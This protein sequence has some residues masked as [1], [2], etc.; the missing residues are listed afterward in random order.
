[1]LS[2]HVP[3][4][5]DRSSQFNEANNEAIR[6]FSNHQDTL[7]LAAQSE[8]YGLSSC[9]PVLKVPLYKK[10]NFTGD[11]NTYSEGYYSL[12]S[13]YGIKDP[14]HLAKEAIDNERIRFL[15]QTDKGIPSYVMNFLEK[16]P[17]NGVIKAELVDTFYTPWMGEWG[18]YAILSK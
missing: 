10:A 5:R 16:Y 18:V 6:Y 11:W 3:Y 8:V 7:F 1:M 9:V 13:N 4:Y 17:H 2:S 15:A 12:T 14:D